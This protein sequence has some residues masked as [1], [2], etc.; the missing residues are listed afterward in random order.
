MVKI[1][2][3]KELLDM[4]TRMNDNIKKIEYHEKNTLSAPR[5]K[6]HREVALP[7]MEDTFKE[8][9][10]P[11]ESILKEAKD[12]NIEEVDLPED[13]ARELAGMEQSIGMYDTLITS[14]LQL[15]NGEI[16]EAQVGDV[17]ADSMKKLMESKK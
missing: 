4:L 11:L 9:C 14:T 17:L 8:M 2:K 12:G 15:M 13:M 10:E 1:S 16:T 3:A 6:M 7:M 5:K